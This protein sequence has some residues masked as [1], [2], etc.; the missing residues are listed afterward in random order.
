VTVPQGATSE[1]FAITTA[2]VTASTPVTITASAGGITRTA[3]LTVTPAGQLVPLTVTATGRS[4]ERVISN[5][6]GIS[7]SVGS[8]GSASF[9]AGTTI[10]LSATNGRDVVWSGA[11][12]S[13]G[14]KTKSC[15]FTLA[16]TASVTANVQ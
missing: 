9:A 15:T 2:S 12:S 7:V 1:A 8:S 11:C 13:G 16:A 3:T 5:P 4:G 6:S 14:N 10:V